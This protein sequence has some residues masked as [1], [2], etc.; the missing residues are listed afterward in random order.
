MG[1]GKRLALSPSLPLTLPWS[2]FFLFLLFQGGRYQTVLM[3]ENRAFSL[4]SKT[5]RIAI[6]YGSIPI[7]IAFC[8]LGVLWRSTCTC[9]IGSLEL[10]E[11]YLRDR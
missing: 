5:K 3:A 11:P 8:V 4:F 6:Q 2:F 9:I 1:P 7:L 10:K